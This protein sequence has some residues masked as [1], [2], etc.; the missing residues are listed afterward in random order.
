L[1]GPDDCL[2]FEAWS[3]NGRGIGRRRER[4]TD[5]AWIEEVPLERA[6]G[7]LKKLYDDAIRR[8]GRVFNIR[9]AQSLNPE[10]LRDGIRFYA[11]IMT[12]ES[13]LTRVQRELVATVVAVEANC[14]Y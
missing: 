7:L 13:S 12:G 3:I 10:I 9:R 2:I 14:H 6:T 4:A 5:M 11:S 8:A 1:I